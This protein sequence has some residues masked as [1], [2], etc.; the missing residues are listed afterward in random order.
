MKKEENFCRN[1]DNEPLGPWCYTTDPTKRWEYCNVSSCDFPHSVQTCLD[2]GNTMHMEKCPTVYRFHDDFQI[3]FDRQ[4]SDECSGNYST[5]QAIVIDL[6]NKT[7]NQDIC[8][9]YI[10]RLLQDRKERFEMN[11][12]KVKYSCQNNP[13]ETSTAVTETSIE[14][15]LVISIGVAVGLL[16][17]TVVS[18]LLIIFIRRSFGNRKDNGLSN[19]NN[20]RQTHIKNEVSP[21]EITT[22][23]KDRPWNDSRLEIKTR[24]QKYNGSVHNNRCESLTIKIG[25]DKYL[26]DQLLK[27]DYI[28]LDPAE[29]GFNRSNDETIN[30]TY[31][32]AKPINISEFGN[33]IKGEHLDDVYN[34][35]EEGVYDTACKN[36]RKDSDVSVYS[37]TV[38]DVYDT[39]CSKRT[40]V[41]QEDKYDHF[42]GQT[43]E[44][45]YNIKKTS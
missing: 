13:K 11:R 29:T 4:L 20:H 19:D 30:G 34:L 38:D 39:A 26:E 16:L 7:N 42:T 35:S 25:N 43:T 3:F 44:D 2:V 14:S 23:K 18:I 31:E 45:D 5:A 17:L 8:S 24:N 28:V 12:L 15:V 32:L 6:C 1:P 36:R 40:V 37:H 41:F 9:V 27:T 33:K 21:K 10:L 22:V